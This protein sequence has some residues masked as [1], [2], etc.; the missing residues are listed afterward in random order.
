MA[1]VSI[2]FQVRDLPTREIERLRGE[3]NRLQREFGSTQQS[4]NRAAQGVREVGQT[5]QQ[6]AASVDRLGDE[7]QQAAIGIDTLGRQIFQTSA[8]AK[9]FG[10]IFQDANGRLREANGRYA[11]ASVGIRELTTGLGGASQ[12]TQRF[13]ESLGGANRG[14]GVFTASLGNLRGILGGIGIAV[15]TQQIA[16]FGAESIRAAGRLD[17]LVRATTQIEGSSEAAEQ[18]I[19]ALIQVANL[20]GLQFEP[21]VRYSNRLR[22]AGLA[23][24]DVDKILLTVG[25][26]VVSLGGSAATAELAMEQLIQAF[27]LGKVDFRDFRT[28]VQQIPGFLEAMGDVHG[29]RANL[30]GLHEAFRRTGG[31]IRDLVIPTFDELS[32]RFEAPPSDSYIVAIDTLENAFRLAQAS[33]GSLFLP[34]VVEAAQGLTAFFEAIRAG[35]KDANTLPEPIQDIVRGAQALFDALQTIAGQIDAGIGDEVRQLLPAL[36]TLIGSILELVGAIGT[37]LSPMLR[38]WAEVQSVIVALVTKLAQDLSGLISVVADFVNWVNSLWREEDMAADATEKLTEAQNQLKTATEGTTQAIEN[39]SSETSNAA[40]SA[41]DYAKRLGELQ[42]EL[43]SVNEQLA[44]KKASLEEL[45]EAGRGASASAQQLQRQITALEQ[46][47]ASLT[48]Q[49]DTLKQGLVSVEQP[50]KDDEVAMRGFISSVDEFGGELERVDPRFLTFNERGTVLASTIRALPPELTEVSSDF[51]NLSAAIATG[52][53]ALAIFTQATEQVGESEF[54]QTIETYVDVLERLGVSIV[55]TTGEM[56]ALDAVSQQFVQN[57]QD[58]EGLAHLNQVIDRRTDPRTANLVN[59]RISEASERFREYAEQLASAQ[60]STQALA[61]ITSG[62]TD[63]I[64]EFANETLTA[65]GVLNNFAGSIDEV[66]REYINLQAVS[67]HLTTSI[68]EQA[69]AFDDL[70]RSVDGISQSASGLQGQQLGSDV[71]DRF[72][73]SVTATRG[74]LDL[75]TGVMDTLSDNTDIFGRIA[76]TAFDEASLS[77][78]RMGGEVD[79]IG[80]SLLSVGDLVGRLALGDITALIEAPFRVAEIIDHNNAIA[81]ERREARRAEAVEEHTA[82]AFRFGNLEAVGRVGGIEDIY[83]V[84]ALGGL[85]QNLA[86]L[87]FQDIAANIESAADALNIDERIED[88]LLTLAANLDRAITGADID[89]IYAPF[90]DSLETAMTTAGTSFENVIGTDAPTE[91][92][93]SSF[94]TYLS[95]I[96]DYFDTQIQAVRTQ[97]Q[98]TGVFLTETIRAIEA[99]RAETL[100]A[101][102]QLNTSNVVRFTPR[103]ERGRS[104]G[105]RYNASLGLFEDIPTAGSEALAPIGSQD[106]TAPIGEITPEELIGISDLDIS[107]LELAADAAIE[108]FRAAITAPAR[109][110]ESIDAALAELLPELR[111]LY[112]SLREQIIGTDGIISEAE[113]IQLN[114]LGSF[115]DFTQQYIELGNDARQEIDAAEQALASYRAGTTFSENIQAF[116]ASINAAGVTVEDVNQAFVDLQPVLRTEFERLRAE[117][118]GADGVVSATEQLALEEQGLASFEDFTAPFQELADTAITG[119]QTTSQALID[120]DANSTFGRNVEVFRESVNAAGNTVSDINAEWG[121]FVF[122]V[123]QPRFAYLRSQILDDDGVITDAE[124]LALKEAGLDSFQDFTGQF[125]SIRDTAVT[126]IQTIEQD[127]SEFDANHRFSLNVEAFQTGLDAAGLTVEAIDVAFSDFQ[128]NVLRPRFEYLRSQILDGDGV[129]SAA[130]ELALKEAGLESFQEFASGFRQLADDAIAGV[131]SSEQALSDFDAN[132]TFAVNVETFKANINAAGETIPSINEH[133]A[134]FQENVLR[135]RFEYLRSEILDDDGVISAAEELALKEANLFTFEDF[136]G[137]FIDLRDTAVSGIEETAQALSDFDANSTF[138]RNAE[139][140]KESV[141]QAG[142]TVADINTAFQT[143]QENVLRPRF[144]YLRSQILDG[145]GV[146]SEA[147]ELSLKEAGLY[148]FEDFTSAFREIAD[149]AV[150]GIQGANQALAD[151]RAGNTFSDNIEA[152]RETINAVG[153]TIDEINQAIIDLQPVIRAEYERLREAVIGNRRHY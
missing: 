25:Q 4:S 103:T 104:P 60:F 88:S 1:D 2:R 105:S 38:L 24:E 129:I 90:L 81:A 78:A 136:S 86:S 106:P 21:L 144:D 119:I 33:I 5:S 99:V 110:I 44:D 67:D 122:N 125:V 111:T 36:G 15:V 46:R 45:T 71:F 31:S 134:D 63:R 118:I 50:M 7:A 108:T 40:E 11:A 120:F 13:T 70:R 57:T 85:R 124:S 20:P 123:L 65:E 27:Q 130:E 42:P 3:V 18:R 48:G 64:Q 34:T 9:R 149:T 22:A 153:V 87:D 112:D 23:G 55:D 12:G 41:E 143:F 26:T 93:T 140:F 84:D 74:E 73:E 47:S 127:L 79:T 39:Q 114:N 17:Q 145:D 109:T 92:V 107:N 98:A 37:A 116:R 72:D 49:V 95:T 139:A 117:I 146:I 101:A 19:E 94:N 62:S 30:E 28:I 102:R 128:E 147:E 97:E 51:D 137:Q 133:W 53:G 82:R 52:S 66:E 8:E 32:R 91:V 80:E 89:A 16:Q 152:F 6:A 56:A 126:G 14:T 141:N 100:N 131:E 76:V 115:E 43:A 138:Q 132:S 59:P 113:Q 150:T 10:G 61:E 148:S 142:N 121:R 68:R 29:V 35:V 58:A 151:Y 77:I 96:N 83:A 69:S 135:P 54:Y 75:V